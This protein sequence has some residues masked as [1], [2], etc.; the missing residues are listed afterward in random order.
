MWMNI[1]DI[2]EQVQQLYER[3]KYATKEKILL[4]T[5]YYNRIIQTHILL[6]Y[7]INY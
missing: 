1:L 5:K 6:F 3:K 2:I 4:Q 7:L